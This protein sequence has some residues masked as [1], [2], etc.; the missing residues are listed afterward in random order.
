MS[1][2]KAATLGG[3]IE[4]SDEDEGNIEAMRNGF[5]D[6]VFYSSP[7]LPELR[8]V[9]AKNSDGCKINVGELMRR[10]GNYW[11]LRLPMQANADEDAIERAVKVERTA[12][13]LVVSAV[14]RRA[15]SADDG[16]VFGWLNEAW[17]WIDERSR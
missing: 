14:Q 1:N 15:E 9:E 7:K 5:V 16:D 6:I 11:V 10:D 2:D 8:F 4:L 3:S 17:H 12:C 13:L